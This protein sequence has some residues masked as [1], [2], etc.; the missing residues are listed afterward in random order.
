M[1][2]PKSASEVAEQ[3]VTVGLDRGNDW[4]VIING[5]EI[6]YWPLNEMAEAVAKR[7]RTQLA[8]LISADRR[9]RERGICD[10]S[11]PADA[12]QEGKA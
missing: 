4:C 11:G 3:A 5:K 2:S 6:D 9:E 7:I 1:T 12:G 8:A 10:L